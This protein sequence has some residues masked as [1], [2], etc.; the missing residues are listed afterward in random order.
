LIAIDK[1]IKPTPYYFRPFGSMEIPKMI[2]QF[3][4]ETN[5]DEYAKPEDVFDNKSR[6]IEEIKDAG[7]DELGN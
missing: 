2:D 5:D 3:N 7:D 6:K 1:D 4:I